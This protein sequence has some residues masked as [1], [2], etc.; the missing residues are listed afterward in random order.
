MKY[1]KTLV[2]IRGVP[3][4]GKTTMA[5]KMSMYVFEADDYFMKDG[6][7]TFVPELISIAHKQCEMR[8]RRAME[9]EVSPIVVANT[10]SRKWEMRAY[11]EMAEKYGYRVKEYTVGDASLTAAD[12]AA[13]NVHGV[14]ADRIQA[15]MDW[16]EK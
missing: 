4:A 9:T 12:Y 11:H 8:V 5:R 16:W 2:I 13:R 14:P 6:V 10:F 1:L 15:M 7:Y 3:G